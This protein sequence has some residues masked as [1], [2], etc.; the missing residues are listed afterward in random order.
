MERATC[1]SWLLGTD[2]YKLKL[3]TTIEREAL[4]CQEKA[5]VVF[6]GLG[7]RFNNTEAAG[8]I[9]TGLRRAIQFSVLNAHLDALL[10]GTRG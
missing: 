7:I 8:F 10:L 5:T 6:K 2:S 3:V 1:T 9:G 4:M